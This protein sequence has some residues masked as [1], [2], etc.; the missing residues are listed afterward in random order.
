MFLCV[1]YTCQYQLAIHRPAHGSAQGFYQL[2][3]E[4][5]AE[6]N[7]FFSRYMSADQVWFWMCRYVLEAPWIQ[8]IHSSRQC[9]QYACIKKVKYS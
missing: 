2:K 4:S 1:I 9:L 3:P 6:F 7:P 5:W 8:L